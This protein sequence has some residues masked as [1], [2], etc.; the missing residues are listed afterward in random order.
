M[1]Q[2][3]VNYASSAGLPIALTSVDKL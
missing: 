2:H 3:Q 1:A